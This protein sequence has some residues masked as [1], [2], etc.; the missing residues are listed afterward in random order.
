MSDRLLSFAC[1]A[2]MNV[3]VTDPDELQRLLDYL[4]SLQ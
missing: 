2:I 1:L 3:A 4:E